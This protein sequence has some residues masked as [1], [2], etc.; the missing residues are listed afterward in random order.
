MP[1]AVRWHR[2]ELGKYNIP[3]ALDL[4]NLI[5]LAVNA[6]V[7]TPY[8]LYADVPI[9]KRVLQ[10]RSDFIGWFIEST[11]GTLEADASGGH[12]SAVVRDTAL[13][14]L[15]S[16]TL[17]RDLIEFFLRLRAELMRIL[18]ETNHFNL[19]PV[20][21]M[22]SDSAIFAVME[23]EPT[24]ATTPVPADQPPLAANQPSE[25]ATGVSSS[26]PAAANDQLAPS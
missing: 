6:I 23:Y 25:D 24:T 13:K 11:E 7:S 2:Q 14:E 5:A 4:D 3:I 20:P 10:Q 21:Q 9:E 1:L 8:R 17:A 19:D 18:G 15:Y 16:L 26:H 22:L 12:I